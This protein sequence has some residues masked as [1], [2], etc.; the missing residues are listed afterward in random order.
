[1]IEIDVVFGYLQKG[2]INQVYIRGVSLYLF[3]E[4]NVHNCYY[5]VC[6]K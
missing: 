6:M 1:M 2:T 4:I 3:A 5:S